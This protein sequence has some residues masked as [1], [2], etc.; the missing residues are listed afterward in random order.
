MHRLNTVPNPGDS[1]SI[2]SRTSFRSKQREKQNFVNASPLFVNPISK[3]S[4]INE[5]VIP[6]D[7]NSTM[8]WSLSTALAIVSAIKNVQTVI[9]QRCVLPWPRVQ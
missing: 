7:S 3:R 2:F 6:D 9:G 1:T 4:G 5:G 8:S